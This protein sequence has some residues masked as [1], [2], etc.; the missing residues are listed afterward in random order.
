MWIIHYA[1]VR[2]VTVK[3]SFHQ[4]VRN[5]FLLVIQRRE[6]FPNFE[7]MK[8]TRFNISNAKFAMIFT[9]LVMVQ[10]KALANL[11]VTMER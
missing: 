7:A 6:R 4:M 1:M 5:V 3:L 2:K 8:L 10:I 9:M 11:D